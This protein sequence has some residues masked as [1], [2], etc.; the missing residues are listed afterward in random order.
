MKSA[1]FLARCNRVFLVSDF[2]HDTCSQKYK[3]GSVGFVGHHFEGDEWR[4]TQLPVMFAIAKGERTESYKIMLEALI[5]AFSPVSET[6]LLSGLRMKRPVSE[7]GLPSGLKM[8]RPVSETGCPSG[9]RMRRP[10]SEPGL[11]S[12]LTMKRLVSEMCLFVSN[13]GFS[14]SNPGFSVSNPAF[15]FPIRAF[16]SQSGPRPLVE[17]MFVTRNE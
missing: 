10:V 5:R 1:A 9:L 12:G 13:P 7:K 6:G 4:Q 2:T 11:P 17:Y 3:T 8:K 16:C 14:V 15:V